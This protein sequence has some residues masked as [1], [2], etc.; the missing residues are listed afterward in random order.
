MEHWSLKYR[1]AKWTDQ[2]DCLHWFRKISEEQF[3]RTVPECNA[4]DYQHHLRST[5]KVMR[6]NIAEMFGYEETNTPSEGDAVFLS[7]GKLEHHIGMVIFLRKK[8]YVLH[9]LDGAGMVVSDLMD[10]AMNGW[11]ILSYWTPCD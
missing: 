3:G 6:G 5:I 1:E 10:L 11:K 7:Q 2:T 4:I 8:L 9:V